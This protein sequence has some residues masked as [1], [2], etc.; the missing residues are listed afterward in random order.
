MNLSKCETIV[1]EKKFVE[2]HI[3]TI[4]RNVNNPTFSSFKERLEKFK[5][6]KSNLIKSDKNLNNECK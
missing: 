1:D 5:E 6:L 4:E 2:A 3:A